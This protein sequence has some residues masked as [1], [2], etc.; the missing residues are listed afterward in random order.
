MASAA[1]AQLSR[2][3]ARFDERWPG[4]RRRIGG[5][6][7]AIAI[8]TALF[9]AL[10]TLGV[11]DASD[12]EA[13]EALTTVDFSPEPPA[14]EQPPEPDAPAKPSALPRPAPQPRPDQPERENPVLPIPVPP[15]AAVLPVSKNEVPVAQPPKIKAV[16]RDDAQGPS[17]PPNTARSGDSERVGTR[18]NGE[19]VYRA[20]WYREP[21]DDELRG[22]LSTASGPGWAIITC[23][24]VP[25]FRVE[26]CEL[27]NEYPDGAQIGRAVLAAA[28]QFKVRPPQIGGRVLVGEWVRIRITYEIRRQ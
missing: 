9:L 20:R 15:P 4:T 10:L 1:P 5:F 2:L 3:V 21:T 18:A 7:L 6:A 26:D 8:E 12:K 27:E 19:P 22:Y 24:T 25:G 16:V 28:W 17:G 14:P 13:A 23:R 11:S